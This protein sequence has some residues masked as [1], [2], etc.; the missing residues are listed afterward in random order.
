MRRAALVLLFVVAMIVG[1]AAALPAKPDTVIVGTVTMLHVDDLAHGTAKMRLGVVVN[2]ALVPVKGLRDDDLGRQ[3]HLTGDYHG[4]TFVATGVEIVAPV[5]F[6]AA[7]RT[8]IAVV[9]MNFTDDRSEPMTVAQATALY[10][11]PRPSVRDWYQT[12]S[13]GQ[14]N[15]T[16]T[17]FP[18]VH[19]NQAKSAGCNVTSW[20][21]EANALVDHSGYDTVV[22]MWPPVASCAFTGYASIGAAVINGADPSRITTVIHEVGHTRGLEHSQSFFCSLNGAAVSLSDSCASSEYG[23]TFDAMGS[24]GLRGFNEWQRAELGW[25]TPTTIT[26]SGTYTLAPIDNTTGQRFL[27]VA[28]GNGDYLNLE[29]R[30]D[31]ATG[32]YDHFQP[33][34]PVV[35][36]VSI[37]VAPDVDPSRDWVA[38]PHLIDATPDTPTM[39]DSSLTVGKSLTDPKTGVKI[40]TLAVSPAGASVQIDFGV[41]PPT[42]TIPTTTTTKPPVT[43]TSTPPPTTTTAPPTGGANFVQ[44]VASGTKSQSGNTTLALTLTA[45]VAAGHRVI[46]A[47]SVGTF[48]GPV[49]CKDSRGNTYTIDA[50]SSNVF[51]CSSLLTTA[52]A[53]GDTLTLTYPGFSGPSTALAGDYTAPS[54]DGNRPGASTS[55]KNVS[56]TPALSTATPGVIVS[57]V[58]SKPGFAAGNGFTTTGAENDLNVGFRTAQAGSYAALGSVSTGAW[59]AVL[60]AYH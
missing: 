16:G 13:Y 35:L 49:A 39:W 24:G 30:R 7:P 25:L 53:S 32:V 37:R 9:L 22:Y 12:M 10:F 14:L 59:R 48:A 43:T 56:V 18:W 1:A 58:S 50:R 29:Y 40:T 17:V 60:V 47:A 41:T 38:F 31:D 19:L 11:G 20:Q 23:D 54:V 5:R 51:V 4:K 46:A 45:P 57:V 44:Q 6:S 36:G 8:S 55:T 21:N 34:W 26:S 27:R 42:T 15:Y 3:V 52:L 2:G 33:D 28:R